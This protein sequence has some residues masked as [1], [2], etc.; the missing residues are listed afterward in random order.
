MARF[1]QKLT[2]RAT[3][4]LSA[5]LGSGG[6]VVPSPAPAPARSVERGRRNVAF[7]ET[8]LTCCPPGPEEREKENCTI[9]YFCMFFLQGGQAEEKGRRSPFD[10]VEARRGEAR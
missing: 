8:L 9:S 6:S 2:E 10:S 1:R 3:S 5:L 4:I 7:V